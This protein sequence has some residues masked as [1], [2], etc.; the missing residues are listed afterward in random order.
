MSFL[1]KDVGIRK[2]KILCSILMLLFSN[3]MF[4][5]CA[6]TTSGQTPPGDFIERAESPHPFMMNGARFKPIYTFHDLSRYG[7]VTSGG[8]A[9]G[10]TFV[11]VHRISAADVGELIGS[12]EYSTDE[13]LIGSNVYWSNHRSDRNAINRSVVVF[14]AGEY[15]FYTLDFEMNLCFA[16][17][18]E[19]FDSM[20]EVFGIP[21]R[22]IEM[23]VMSGFMTNERSIYDTETIAAVFEILAPYENIGR[24]AYLERLVQIWYEAYGTNEVRLER[25]NLRIAGT[26]RRRYR[27][28]PDMRVSN[29]AHALWGERYTLLFQTDHW[30]RFTITYSPGI[31]VFQCPSGSGYFVLS[32]SDVSRL[33]ELLRLE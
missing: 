10:E 27:Y 5:A 29:K 32:D 21:E 18:N 19:R 11:S 3:I 20:Y 25:G 7:Y 30:H 12:V 1:K 16:A 31:A 24:H 4:A 22:V 8:N 28:N 13:S 6:F 2:L 33:N 26:D 14:S 17:N 9:R 23:H 15:T